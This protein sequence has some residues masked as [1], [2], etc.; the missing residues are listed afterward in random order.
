MLYHY[1]EHFKG[2]IVNKKNLLGLLIAVL[3]L[4]FGIFD[5]AGVKKA[6]SFYLNPTDPERVARVVE[7]EIKISE[8]PETS[9]II[10]ALTQKRIAEE[11]ER[12]RQ[13][14]E[15]QKYE[16]YRI[17]MDLVTKFRLQYDTRDLYE[18]D[19]N[20]VSKAAPTKIKN[21]YPAYKECF[22][23]ENEQCVFKS[24]TLR[25]LAI[26]DELQAIFITIHRAGL[27]LFLTNKFGTINGTIFLDINADDNMIIAFLTKN[28]AVANKK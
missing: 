12:Q 6:I 18:M 23:D 27:A 16:A 15:W 13:Q 26:N 20:L 9:A 1:I 28:V 24:F 5:P 8:L 10:V 4:V 22:S 21:L 14:K 7:S 3:L 19:A 25:R 17:H 11:E 2:G